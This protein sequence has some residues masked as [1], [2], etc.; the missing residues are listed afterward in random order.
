MSSKQGQR[1]SQP[2]WY[3]VGLDELAVKCNKISPIR[4]IIY[5]IIYERMFSY[6]FIDSKIIA[7]NYTCNK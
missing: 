4:N 7:G 3:A 1:A 5:V 6:G 2:F